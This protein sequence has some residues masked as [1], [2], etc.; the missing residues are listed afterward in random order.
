MKKTKSHQN[1]K[2]HSNIQNKEKY[3]KIY[4]KPKLKYNVTNYYKFNQKI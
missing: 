3:F 2:F 4:N 1:P